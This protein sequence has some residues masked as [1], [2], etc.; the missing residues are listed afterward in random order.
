MGR[1]DCNRC[2]ENWTTC[3]FIWSQRLLICLLHTAHHACIF[4]CAC[5]FCSVRTLTQSLTQSQAHGKEVHAHEMNSSISNSFN[6]LCNAEKPGHK[7][8]P[9]QGLQHPL[10][11][12]LSLAKKK[13]RIKFH[14]ILCSI[15][16]EPGKKICCQKDGVISSWKP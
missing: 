3:S 1:M 10:S 8:K 4:R 14:Q 2:V 7:E 12:S 5:L 9:R 11:F 16:H 15:I 6:P 13:M